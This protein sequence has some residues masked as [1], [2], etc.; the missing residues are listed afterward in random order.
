MTATVEDPPPLVA[1]HVNVTPAVSAA[2]V[3]AAHAGVVIKVSGSVTVQ[4][5][6]TLLVYQPFCPSVPASAGVI[7][8]GVVSARC[9]T[10]A[11]DVARRGVAEPDHAGCWR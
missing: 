6:V 10:T 3:L 8:G 1:E 9:Q 7:T 11:C 2:T 4:V 5:T